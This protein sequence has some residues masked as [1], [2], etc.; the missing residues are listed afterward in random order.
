MASDVPDPYHYARNHAAGPG[1]WCVRGPDG[2]EMALPTLT[3]DQAWFVG[4]VL[5]SRWG[6]VRTALEDDESLV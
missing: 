3:K 1:Q 2:F 6:E 5:S 4:K